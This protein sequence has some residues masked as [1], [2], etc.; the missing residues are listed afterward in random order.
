MPLP[1]LNNLLVNE[2]CLIF[3]ALV[4]QM[5]SFA[6]TIELK[7]SKTV[8]E[9]CSKWSQFD[10]VSETRGLAFVST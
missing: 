10:A 8:S 4:L 7:K 6:L 5:R 2:S 9:T 3:C 1:K